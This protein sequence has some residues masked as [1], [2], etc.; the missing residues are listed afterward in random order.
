MD[1]EE[2]F[3]NKVGQCSLTRESALSFSLSA[4]ER[5]PHKA[6]EEI[7]ERV[8]AHSYPAAI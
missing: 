2:Y 6:P 3:D 8:L 7:S 4:R 1:E 5:N